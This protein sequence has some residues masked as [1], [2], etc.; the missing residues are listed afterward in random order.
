M[1]LTFAIIVSIAFI[2]KITKTKILSPAGIQN[3]MWIFFIIGAYALLSKSYSF[4]NVG[5]IW[6]VAYCLIN[7]IF[8]C[9]ID[10]SAIQK[11]TDFYSYYS[12]INIPWNLLKLF[13]GLSFLSL[14]ITIVSNGISI[15]SINSLSSLQS[16][17]NQIA[18]QHYSGDANNSTLLLLL[19]TFS[20]ITPLCSGYSLIYAINK[21]QKVTCFF[22]SVPVIVSSILT[23]AKSGVIAYVIL[24][25]VGYVT[26]YICVNHEVPLINIK[27]FIKIIIAFLALMIFF[28]FTFWLRIGENG[29]LYNMIVTKLGEYA[30]GHIQSFDQWFSQFAFSVKPRFGAS[31]FLAISSK[32]SGQDKAAGVY[33]F[34]N[35]SCTN[36]FTQFRPLIE[37]FTP[38]I[39]LFILLL[40]GAITSFQYVEL[41]NG[42][43][44]ITC[45][46][47]F[48]VNMFYLLYFIISAWT[49]TS[50]MI[51]FFVYFIYIFFSNKV[52]FVS[53]SI[54]GF[55][56]HK[57]F[58]LK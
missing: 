22:S 21:N 40:I 8:Y 46:F 16:T 37:D 5:I 15:S 3:A 39:A 26:S 31:T 10:S 44:T 58:G 42:R 25:F 36:V 1:V 27:V 38:I 48:S 53:T 20:Y 33:D 56:T 7:T 28:Y 35:G 49:Y 50:Y 43:N 57:K 11:D 14:L 2:M 19:N 24:F 32:L 29:N 41:K 52:K 34:I 23:T 17:S 12:N 45:Q 55:K 47:W 6:I 18:I 54:F 9:I 4:R 13:I 51:A 30:F